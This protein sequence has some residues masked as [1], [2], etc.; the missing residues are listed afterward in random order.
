MPLVIKP[1]Q[2]ST[3]AQKLAAKKGFA[4]WA[5]SPAGKKYAALKK[6]PAKYAAHLT[7]SI[8]KVQAWIA[9]LKGSNDP[10]AAKKVKNHQARIKSMQESIKKL[11]AA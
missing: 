1:A 10:L 6:D 7:Q 11:R 8:K 5:K 9:G 4:K 2:K 3:P